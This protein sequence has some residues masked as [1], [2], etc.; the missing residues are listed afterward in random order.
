MYTINCILIFDIIF[1]AKHLINCTV[2]YVLYTYCKNDKNYQNAQY[3]GF[4][5]KQVKPLGL[6]NY[7]HLS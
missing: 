5:A 6:E 7:F 4:M 2:M 3:F 1:Y